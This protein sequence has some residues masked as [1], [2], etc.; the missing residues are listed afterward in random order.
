MKLFFD[1][2]ANLN[3]DED[4]RGLFK[5]V[6]VISVTNVKAGAYLRVKIASADIIPDIFVDRMSNEIK[7]QIL[8]GKLGVHIEYENGYEFA[9]AGTGTYSNNIKDGKEENSNSNT[10]NQVNQSP[11]QN[12]ATPKRK[13]SSKKKETDPDMLYGKSFSGEF[14]PIS[15]I[16]GDMKDVIVR[17]EIFETELSV[18]KNGFKIFK[19]AITDYKDSIFMKMFLK[20]GEEKLP[21]L[22]K[23]GMVIEARGKVEYDNYE[24]EILITRI[25]GIRKSETPINNRED[26]S[27]QKRVELHLHTR[28]SDMD[29]ITSVEDLLA[30]ATKWG[31]KAVAITDHGVVQGFT[32]AF[33]EIKKKKYDIKVIYGCEG[34][35]VDD[36]DDPIASYADGDIVLRRE[37]A[38]EDEVPIEPNPDEEAA[39]TKVKKTNYN[40]IILLAKNEIGRVNLYRLVSYAHVNYFSRRPRIPRSVLNKYREGLIV[41]SACVAGELYEALL[42]GKSEETIKK[43]VDFYD[44]LEIQP[45]GNNYYL[46]RNY[47]RGDKG[48]K[49]KNVEEI[50]EYNRKI[51]E[52]GKK[53][54]KKVVA[55]GDV[56]FLNP[57][58]EVYRRIIMDSQ[59]YADADEQAPL[60][61]RTTEE[62]LSEF[63]YLGEDIA[64]EIV[65]DNTNYIADQIEVIEP[66]R[67]DK[68]PPVI[69]NSDEQLRNSCYETAKKMYGENLPQ[70]VIDRLEKELNSIISNGYSVMYIIAKKLVQKSV[71]DGYLVG[72]RGS[73]GS[74]FAATMS[75]ITEVNPLRPHYRCPKCLYSDFDSEEVKAFAG[76]AGCDMPDKVCPVCGEP[77]I[78]DG[79]D[80]PFETFLGF[81]GDKEPD[82]DLNFSGEYQ[83][84][85]HDYTE[86]IFG[87]GQ[88]FRAG[89]ISALK[90]KTIYG[91]VKGYYER[92]NQGI[93]KC[94]MNRLIKG[95]MGVKR[96]TGQ[97]PGGIIVLPHGEEIYSFTPIQFPAN[98]AENNPVTTHFDYHSIDHNLLKL[99]ILGHDDPTMIRMLE[100]LTGIDAKQIK[101][102]DPSVMKLFEGTDVLGI[103]PEDID[104]PLGTLGIPEFGTDFVMQMLLDTH[105][106]N[107]SDLVRIAGL[108]HGT[109]VWLGNA[110]KLIKDGE[111]TLSTCICTRDDIMTYLINKGIEPSLAFDVMEDVRKGNVAKGFSTKWPDSEKKL[112]AA[113]IPD[114]YL[115]SCTKIQYMFPKAHAVA[116]VMM[117]YRIA[118]YKIF[119][120]IAYYA[121][122]FSI[123]ASSFDYEK[124]CQGPEKLNHEMEMIK[125]RID[126]EV[127]TPK[128]KDLLKYMY[129]VKEMYARGIEFIPIDIYKASANRFKIIDNK[130]MP[131]FE[132]I[133]GMGEKAAF[134]L[135]EEA[136]KEKFVSREELKT[137]AKLSGTLIDKLY[138]IGVVSDLPETSQLSILDF[139]KN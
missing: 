97:H 75:G 20:E 10:G 34:Y 65:I 15:H 24:G 38:I 126:N 44:Y 106:K 58:D 66:V 139:L 123:R 88:T 43:I 125:Q 51:Y 87:K 37:S 40:H 60:Y 30:T 84:N 23:E 93:K 80:I 116:Y 33:H 50:Q 89:T 108:S 137:R 39:I 127:A 41:G 130:I 1:V 25:F 119:Y 74:S 99:D 96:S 29:A 114:W 49:V 21:E 19:I 67:P 138:E 26:N 78:K 8:E 69:E 133:D 57:E 18:T 81:K 83:S 129:N 16:I 118:Y 61:F 91:F 62:M 132:S 11:A 72:S 115:R 42:S 82:I 14:T 52:L 122:F 107:F 94:E 95:C 31:H 90:D 36:D 77:L 112:K 124:M 102:D 28:Y 101:L 27:P 110:D 128:D 4:L 48:F 76:G 92:H 136:K 109:D 59:K 121:A 79:F 17:G 71:E 3:I 32:D 86:V 68:C 64:K 73:V 134:M 5:D 131:A 70:I 22:F 103:T 47:E 135:E 45:V 63:S 120:P 2:F 6:E 104:K 7:N 9:Q 46:V 98:E 117:A 55:T 54:G 53:Y 85:A 56:H 105:P 35:L 111:A 12:S 113:G 13:F 100:D